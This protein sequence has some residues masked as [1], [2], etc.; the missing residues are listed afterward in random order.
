MKFVP[1]FLLIAVIGYGLWLSLPLF[2]PQSAGKKAPVAVCVSVPPKTVSEKEKTEAFNQARLLTFNAKMESTRPD[3]KSASGPTQFPSL[4]QIIHEQVE[5][6]M[7]PPSQEESL[8]AENARRDL[9]I[10]LRVGYIYQPENG[11]PFPVITNNEIDRTVCAA[12]D[13]AKSTLRVLGLID[14]NRIAWGK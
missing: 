4:T 8:L 9:S 14:P 6:G 10:Q 7:L 1:I 11:R 13:P 3:D 5:G 12:D 2:Y